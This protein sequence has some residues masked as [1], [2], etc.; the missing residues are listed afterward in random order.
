MVLGG[1][2]IGGSRWQQELPIE[3]P[4]RIRIQTIVEISRHDV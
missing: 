2:S 3:D 1:L 4:P